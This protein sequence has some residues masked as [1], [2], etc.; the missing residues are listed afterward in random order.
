MNIHLSKE[1]IPPLIFQKIQ[2]INVT[3]EETKPQNKFQ[4]SNGLEI[5]TYQKSRK[6]NLQ[7]QHL[8]GLE[9]QRGYKILFVKPIWNS[10]KI[11]KTGLNLLNMSRDI[12]LENQEIDEFEIHG[13]KPEKI[14]V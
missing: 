13:T 2:E 8:N 9:I 14:Q 3:S 4:E 6:V 1:N 5:I 12:E 7:E 10:F 11:Q